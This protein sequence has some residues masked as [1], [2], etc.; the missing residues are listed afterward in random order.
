MVGTMRKRIENSIERVEWRTLSPQVARDVFIL[1]SQ[2]LSLVE[3]ACSVV[4]D[5]TDAVQKLLKQGSISK[6]TL[7]Q[8]QRWSQQ[9]EKQFHAV[10]AHPFVLIQEAYDH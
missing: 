1:V 9:P 10:I 2:D 6:P 5:D 3:T 8:V 7:E 4:E